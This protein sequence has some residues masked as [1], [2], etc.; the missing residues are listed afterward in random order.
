M[1]E[2]VGDGHLHDRRA[3]KD[4]R[5]CSRGTVDSAA[6]DERLPAGVDGDLR[7]RAGAGRDGEGDHDRR[8]DGRNQLPP[9]CPTSCVLQSCSLLP[10]SRDVAPPGVRS[11]SRWCRMIP[12]RLPHCPCRGPARGSGLDFPH[13]VLPSSRGALPARPRHGRLRADLARDRP[14]SRRAPLR[15]SACG[16]VPSA[17]RALT[18]LDSAPRGGADLLR[19][20]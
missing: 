1:T 20:S 19:R 11:V 6:C 10:T 9:H 18:D 8:A 12:S 15:R 3:R 16:L 13:R 7:R 2:R 17:C 4:P 14:W 5:P